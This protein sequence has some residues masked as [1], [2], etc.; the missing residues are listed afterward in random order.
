[1]AAMPKG[2]LPAALAVL[3]ACGSTRTTADDLEAARRGLEDVRNRD[4]FLPMVPDSQ[5]RKTMPGFRGRRVPHLA[6]VA[7]HMPETWRAEMA[8]W[9]ALGREGTLDRRL[10]SEVF[11]V[12]SA[13]ND[14]FY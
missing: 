12:V 13:A 11:Y 10:L 8:A 1:M 5:A 2:I 4:A 6:R 3:A 7:A 14:C 9:Q